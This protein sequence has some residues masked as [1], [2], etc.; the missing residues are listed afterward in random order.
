MPKLHTLKKRLEKTSR[1]A[2]QIRADFPARVSR[3]N[4][5]RAK[6]PA[7]IAREKART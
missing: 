1:D 6:R 5:S 4:L 7:L 2:R 3:S